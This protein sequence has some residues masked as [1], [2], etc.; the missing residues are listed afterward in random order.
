MQGFFGVYGKVFRDLGAQE[1]SALQV[2]GKRPAQVVPGFG[3]AESPWSEV[4]AFYQY[5]LQFVSDRSFAWAD[6]HN[7]AAAP[8]RKV[9]FCSLRSGSISSLAAF[10]M[11]GGRGLQ[12]A[13]K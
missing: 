4:S 10:T 12:D 3:R 9:G 1:A 11:P 6:V 2:A 7:L 5:W 8:N 13:C